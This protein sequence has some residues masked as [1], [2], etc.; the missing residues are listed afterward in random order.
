MAL[1]LPSAA[2]L[3]LLLVGSPSLHAFSLTG[4]KWPGTS[5]TIHLQLG[6]GSGTLLDGFTS[7]GASAEDALNVWNAS[8]GGLKFNVVRDSTATRAQGNRTNNVFFSGDIYGQAWGGGVLAVTLIFT[9]GGGATTTETD[10]L[11]NSQL[12][13]NSY[14]GAQRSSGGAAL[15]DFH[16]VAMHEF[17]HALGL[18]HPDQKGQSVAALMNSRIS[19]LDTIT[20]DDIAGAQAL[21]GAPTST[22]P[23]GTAPVITAPP[24]SL[25][26]TAGQSATFTVGVS[27][28]LAVAYQWLKNGGTI[29]GAT[30]ATLAIAATTLADAGNYS[31]VVTNSAGSVT[32]T[33]ATLTVN[34]AAPTPPPAPPPVTPTANAPV[35]VAQPASQT[36]TVGG[37]AT[38][39]VTATGTAPLSYQ[40]RKNGIAI[41]AATAAS[42][43][44]ANLQAG[45]AGSYHVAVANTAGSVV[46]TSATLTINTPPVFSSHPASR[47]L[48]VGSPLALAA[49][50]SGTPPPAYQWFRDNVPLS[51]ATQAALSIA[52]VQLGDAG[53]YRVV[54]TNAA[55]TATST[56]ATVTVH[57][58]PRIT[59]AAVD[60]AVTA[61]ETLSLS[62]AATGTPPPT[63]QWLKDGVEIAGATE[64]RLTIASVRPADA[65]S[66]TIRLTNAAGAATSTAVVTVRSSRLV[67][68]STRGFVPAGGALTPGF[69]LRGGAAKSLVIRAVGPTLSLFGVGT[70]L[71]ET[72]LEV[73]AAD[74]AVVAWNRSW[75]GGAS[76]ASAFARVGAFPLA[77]DSKDA[78]VQTS[79]SPQAYTA[80]VSPTLGGAAGIT[81]AEIYDSDS[82]AA[83]SRLVNVS[84][85][86]FVGAGEEVLT[87][88]FVISGDAPKRLLIRAVGPGLAP[89]GVGDRLADPQISLVPLGRLP[90][91][92]NDDWAD[93]A[94]VRAAFG[95][96]GAF[97]LL[98]GSKDAALVITLEPG[99]YTAVVSGVGA[100]TGNA[101]VEIYDLD[102]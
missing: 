96:A 1:R 18:D 95:S 23:A 101:L 11:F 9:S 31:V 16:R 71:N 63:F 70:A 21:Y 52:A 79:L 33:A 94:S 54:A 30:A 37:S 75:G 14:R 90:L 29:G 72:T 81:L 43:T 100:A 22:P 20:T 57:A 2:A 38:F 60:Q 102:P 61:G 76:L 66:Y 84:T 58:P 92:A 77:A 89:F 39:S 49:T 17:G 56:V 82:L 78:A 34:A 25:T 83:E 19:S 50:V 68:L 74:A 6:S 98:V 45:D 42:L 48:T 67:N 32:S 3:L 28:S 86:G 7:W 53:A 51:G 65:G 93:L 41:T 73:F 91:T 35:I 12:S 8:M 44:L 85:L 40:W 64:A 97:A 80:R 36:A 59:T 26:V 62:V 99:G 27:S 87:A 55:G 10:V 4:A 69:T 24:A 47:T 88:G 46:S 15:Y 13:W 5:T